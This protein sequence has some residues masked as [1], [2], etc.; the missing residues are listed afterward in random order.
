MPHHAAILDILLYFWEQQIINGVTCSHYFCILNNSIQKLNAS[1]KATGSR[2][3]NIKQSLHHI[4]YQLGQV[5]SFNPMTSALAFNRPNIHREV[6][7]LGIK[8]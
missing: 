2:I 4:T 6:H 8:E 1:S 7:L 5:V 3:A